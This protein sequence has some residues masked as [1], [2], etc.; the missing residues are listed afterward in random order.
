ML[1]KTQT[2]KIEAPKFTQIPNVVFDF[3]MGKL[4]PGAFM[5]LVCL[6]RK[7]FG[8]HKTSDVISK[9]QL[10]KLT[11]LSKN[12]IQQAL[13]ELIK[14]GLVLQYQEKNEYGF[15]PNTYSLAIEKPIDQIYDDPD[16]NLGGG[17]SNSDLGVGQKLTQG[18]GQKLTLQ[19][20]DYTKERLTKERRGSEPSSLEPPPPI[21][22]AS[23]DNLSS[24]Q[25]SQK[26]NNQKTEY[27]SFG[28][29]V[30]LKKGDYERL[31]KEITKEYLDYYIEAINNY[32]PNAKP[33]KDYRAAIKQWYLR[34]KKEGKLP[35]PQ[36]LNEAVS[37]A[38]ETETVSNN[39]YWA[40]QVAKRFHNSPKA[41]F[42]YHVDWL[43]ITHIEK[44]EV[45]R[46]Q[47]QDPNFQKKVKE[48]IQKRNL[49]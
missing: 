45:F 29:Y 30:K 41:R 12:T 42:D 22:S 32:V 40:R 2:E 48:E 43:E 10:V 14:I 15:K 20:I 1:V 6:C 47:M 23:S 7:I 44:G 8:W 18:V 16:Q 39:R 3:W 11:G 17:R 33:Y 4:K 38:D 34:D 24:F 27:E 26:L 21:S 35:K 9:N 25:P 5:V 36:K 28:D 31:S 19:N 13:D 46:F 49:L 37:K